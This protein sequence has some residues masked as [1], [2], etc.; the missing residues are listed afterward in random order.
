MPALA[1]WSA[2]GD[3]TSTNYSDFVALFE[4]W[5]N[6]TLRV[7]QMETSATITM[8]SGSGSLPTDYLQWRRATWNGSP[9]QELEYVHPSVLQGYYPTASS[10]TPTLFTIQ[11]SSLN[12]QSTD[13]TDILLEYWQKIS[14]LETNSTNWLMTA[15]P[16]FYLAGT[17]VELY[18]FNKDPDNALIWKGRR[19]ELLGE[20]SRLDKA[21]IGPAAIRVFGPTP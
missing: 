21:S 10:F 7:R 20:I 14:S 4:A 9:T 8:S 12:T 11:G 13:A 2:R 19:D 6:R 3:L 15:H 16:D 17:L 1:S 18:L 5:A